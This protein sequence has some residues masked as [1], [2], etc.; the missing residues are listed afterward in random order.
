MCIYFFQVFLLNYIQEC[1]DRLAKKKE[2]RAQNLAVVKDRPELN[3]ALLDSS[4]KKN[5]AFIK[6]LV[7]LEMM[8]F[9]RYLFIVFFF[10]LNLPSVKNSK[11]FF[12]GGEQ[13]ISALSVELCITY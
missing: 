12:F 11:Y 2:L 6:K 7:S 8:F 4:L 13:F 5:T 3:T 9:I 1:E 10:L